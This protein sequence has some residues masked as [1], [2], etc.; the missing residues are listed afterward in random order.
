[1]YIHTYMRSV[2]VCVCTVY[3]YIHTY[4][5]TGDRYGSSNS[6][7]FGNLMSKVIAM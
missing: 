7:D 5:L 3:I 1:M 4:I 6:V 2:C